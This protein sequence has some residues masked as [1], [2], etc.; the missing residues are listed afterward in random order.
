MVAA[1]IFLSGSDIK[2][3]FFGHE[4]AASK[5]RRWWQGRPTCYRNNSFAING[6]MGVSCVSSDI[7]H[8]SIPPFFSAHSPSPQK[9]PTALAL[10]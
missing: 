8:V 5:A 7:D 6:S 4:E 9:M 10:V 3:D 1:S 2:V